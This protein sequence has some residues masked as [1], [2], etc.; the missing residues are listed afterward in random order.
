MDYYKSPVVYAVKHKNEKTRSL[1]RSGGIFTALSDR[2]FEKSG[3]VYGCILNDKLEVVHIRAVDS[4]GRNLMRGSKY[5]QSNLLNVFSQVKEDLNNGLPVLFSGTSCQ[6][7]GLKSF[8]GKEYENLFTVD[9]IC[10]GVPSA[11]VYRDYIKWNE[12]KY[13]S[14]CVDFNFRNKTDYGWATHIETLTF[15]NG[16]R[17][18][19][20]IYKNFFTGHLIL[21][22]CCFKCPYKSIIHPADISIGDYWGIDK[23][24][25]GFNDNKGVSLVLINND[26]GREMFES[27]TKD[28]EYKTCKIED[29]MQPPLI[30][31]FEIPKNRE[32]FWKEYHEKSFSYIV[33]KYRAVIFMKRAGKRIKRGFS[34]IFDR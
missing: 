2:I 18:D 33:K 13:N 14:K 8:L 21:R 27:S 26:K 17:V 23:A 31:S 30:K 4:Q 29:S 20:N 11:K 9:I 15:K 34:K 6:V 1:S 28:I 3:A 5:V 19:S 7:A 24:C 10:H 25:P 12:E 22:P 16:K 32:N